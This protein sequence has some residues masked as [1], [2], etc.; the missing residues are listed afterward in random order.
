MNDPFARLPVVSNFSLTSTDVADGQALPVAQM[1]AAFGVPGGLDLSPQLSWSG[2]PPETRSYTVTMY[3]PDAPSGSGFWHWAIVDIPAS[4]T[5]LPAGAGDDTGQH[6]PA[7]AFQL[8]NDLGG[9]LL[10]GCGTAAGGRAPPLRHHGA[11]DRRRTRRAAQRAGRFDTGPP[12]LQHQ[13]RRP[14]AR[15]C[16]HHPLGGNTGRVTPRWRAHRLLPEATETEQ[17]GCGERGE[18][19]ARGDPGWARLHPRGVILA[20]PGGGHRVGHVGQPCVGHVGAAVSVV[21]YAV[22]VEADRSGE[23]GGGQPPQA[24]RLGAAS[25]TGDGRR[26]GRVV[27]PAA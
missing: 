13:R 4:V 27:V 18:G 26:A 24:G 19:V 25:R 5:E 6:L 16:G 10:P 11:G 3:D 21:G 2:A 1:S 17:A 15:P 23:L 12:W 22:S 9:P 8:P 14:P 20:G 7:G